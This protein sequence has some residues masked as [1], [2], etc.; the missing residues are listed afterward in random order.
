MHAVDSNY[1]PCLVLHGTED[2]V[3][4]IEGVNQ[5]V[6]HVQ[7]QKGNCTL[8]PFEG[9]GHSFFVPTFRRTNFDRSV[10]EV[11]RFLARL[12]LND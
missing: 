5:F 8:F 11:D 7:S 4:P 12:H 2:R 6:S 3:V 1:P 10:D 9:A